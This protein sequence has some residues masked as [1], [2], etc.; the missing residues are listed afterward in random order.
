MY[1]SIFLVIQII[2]VLVI[3]AYMYYVGYILDDGKYL[4]KIKLGER[5]YELFPFDR[6][7]RHNGL[8]ASV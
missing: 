2:F 7:F 5:H 8:L 4:R 1:E 3:A 6:G